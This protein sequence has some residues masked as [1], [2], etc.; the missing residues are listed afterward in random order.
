M[1]AKK[2]DDSFCENIV[3][4]TGHHVTSP[5]HMYQFSLRNQSLQSEHPFDADHIALHATHKQGGCADSTGSSFAAIL[6]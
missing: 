1:S 6:K 2:G 4:V 3:A 5:R